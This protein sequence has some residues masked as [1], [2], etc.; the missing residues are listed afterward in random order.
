MG[1][2]GDRLKLKVKSPPVEGAANDEVVRFIAESLGLARRQV[3]LLRGQASRQKSV[4]FFGLSLAEL[5]KALAD[6]VSHS[7]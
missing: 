1:W 5:A 7:K 2:H 6:V 4:L 3:S